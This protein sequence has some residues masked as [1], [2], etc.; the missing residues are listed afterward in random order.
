MTEG[1]GARM[2]AE[3]VREVGRT[4]R[5]TGGRG[6]A[7]RVLGVLAFACLAAA[8]APVAS[9]SA[10]SFTWAGGSGGR[11]ESA[12][13]WSASANWEKSPAPTDSQAIE[14]LTFPHLTNGECTSNPPTD[15]C[16]DTLNDLSGLT[17][18]SLQLD[19]ADDYLL[20]GEKI[21][22]SDGLT[23]A[24]PAGTSGPAG[25]FML[26]PVELGASQRWS[27]ANRSGGGIEENGLL[28]GG[29]VTGAPRALTV[30]LSEGPALVLENSTEVGPVTLEG[31]NASGEHIDNGSVL[32][33]E[34]ELDSSDR[35]AVDLRNLFLAGTGAVGALTTSNSTLDVGDETEPAGELTASSATLDSNSA[36]LF[37]VM[38]SGATAQTDYS[39][40]VAQGPVDLAGLILVVVGKPPKAASCPVLTRGQKYTFLSTSGALSGTFA[41]ASEGGQEITIAFTKACSHAPQTMRISYDRSG[42]TET[43]TGTVEAQAVEQ[44]EAETKEREAKE[45]EAKEKEVR[46]KEANEGGRKLAEEGA[47]RAE[48]QAAA[49]K[50]LAEEAAQAATAK[51]HQEEEVA[52]LAVRKRL[53]EEAGSAKNEEATGGVSLDGSTIAVQS[54]GAGAVK[55]RCAGTSACRG[56]L[57]LTAKGAAKKGRRGKTETIGS[58]GFSIAAGKTATVKLTLEAAGRA[59]LSASPGR[60]NAT[61]RILETSPAPS[62][63]HTESVHL[64][65]QQAHGKGRKVG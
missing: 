30:E 17:V 64:V 26:M 51:K 24:P 20:A 5:R 63:T 10:E 12:A 47:K 48:E 49:S 35:E 1:D 4:G 25:S 36:L 16:Y 52:Q 19:D 6:R 3:L 59:L 14:T 28:L 37:E 23:A 18:G 46:T 11:T 34:G 56:K 65:R 15:T 33:E 42:P 50:R 22:L 2:L 7:T 55:L 29:E 40:L 21:T 62:E 38:G 13:H 8:L 41:N 44:Q 54:N 60:L 27:I 39:Q 57:T 53:E 58:A 32:L 43:V 31:P 45:Q 9:A 61:L